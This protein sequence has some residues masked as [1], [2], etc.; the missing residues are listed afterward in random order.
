LDYDP[1][2]ITGVYSSLW[3]NS[4]GEADGIDL[5]GVNVGYKFDCYKAEAEA[6]WFWKRDNSIETWAN[7]ND[8]ANDVHT[9]GIRGSADPIECVT[10]SGE[11]A[12]QVGQYT[13]N[14]MQFNTRDR[15]AWALD[16]AAEYRGLMNCWAWKPKAGIEYILYS[17]DANS[18]NPNNT[19]ASYGGWDRMFRGKYDSAIREWVG[20]YYASYDYEARSNMLPSCSDA[21]YTNQSQ[22]IF[23]GSLQPMDCL[24]L[25]GNWNLF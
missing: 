17:G 15:A 5:W 20:T 24:T 16:V 4:I 11:V 12:A 8:G 23:S 18:T 25:K 1:W 22:L 9:L 3:N 2:T 7:D 19:Q 14:T 13:A 6:Y 21:S 10:V